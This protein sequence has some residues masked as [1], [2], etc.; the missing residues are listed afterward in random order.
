MKT[1]ACWLLLSGA[2]AF[3]AVQTHVGG[4]DWLTSD[5][6]SSTKTV[7]TTDKDGTAFDPKIVF[8]FGPVSRS[9]TTDGVSANDGYIGFGAATGTASR[10][11][12]EYTTLDGLASSSVDKI[13]RNDAVVCQAEGAG[14]G[15]L[16]VDQFG[17]GTNG[18]RYIVDDVLDFTSSR[19]LHVALGGSDITNVAVGEFAEPAATGTVDYTGPGFTPADGDTLI[20]WTAGVT[21]AAPTTQAAS[22]GALMIGAASSAS[23]EM[24]AI[25]FS[26]HNQATMDTY[27]LGKSGSIIA[28]LDGTGAIVANAEFSAWITNGFQLNWTARNSTTRRYFY[29]V[30]K[31]ARV[32]ILEDLTRTSV[33]TFASGSTGFMP[34]AGM[35]LSTVGAEDTTPAVADAKLSLGMF[36]GPATAG[37]APRARML[38][39]L[40][41]QD[42]TANSQVY[43]GGQED[44]V[45][46]SSDQTTIQGIMDISTVDS[47]GVTF[48]Q[49][50]ADTAQRWF[51]G[52]FWGDAAGGVPKRLLTLGVGDGG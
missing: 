5:T 2:Y 11:C 19:V 7:S 35:V 38:R 31:G 52:V 37:S 21:A 51:F 12:A 27:K 10:F 25:L 9:G 14:V 32:K 6:L 18:F 50:D 34:A 44:A 3:G 45:Q 29:A 43:P 23:D 8:Y 13:H 33:T 36:S 48:N 17:G 26:E 28:F 46:V 39:S 30:I 41:D 4:T 1:L 40:D 47:D 16:D 20:L 24:V 42:A 15:R 22:N 49:V